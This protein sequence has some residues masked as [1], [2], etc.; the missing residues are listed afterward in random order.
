[1]VELITTQG[2][3]SGSTVIV[4]LLVVMLCA[5]GGVAFWLWRERHAAPASAPSKFKLPPRA[6][7]HASPQHGPTPAPHASP[8]HGPTPAPHAS[9]QHGPTPAPQS[10]HGPTPQMTVEGRFNHRGVYVSVLPVPDD[11]SAF[12]NA[13][14]QIDQISGPKVNNDYDRVIAVSLLNSSLPFNLYNIGQTTPASKVVQMNLGVIFD[15]DCFQKYVQCMSVTDSGSAQ[16]T[17]KYKVNHDCTCQG[18]ESLN[19]EKQSPAQQAGCATKCG[20]GSTACDAI[21]WCPGDMTATQ[22]A[23]E[24]AGD[25]GIDQCLFRPKGNMDTYVDAAIQW[26]Q[27]YTSPRPHEWKWRETELDAVLPSGPKAQDAVNQCIIGFLYYCT[28]EQQRQTIKTN[29]IKAVRAF[30]QTAGRQAELFEIGS[31]MRQDTFNGTQD[32][33]WDQNNYVSS[34]KAF[35]T[36]IPLNTP[37]QDFS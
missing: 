1:M 28:D 32:A 29:M 4:L 16:R 24:Y 14:Y 26:R 17:C 9:P 31:G 36:K 35:A 21:R 20:D 12:T 2:S 11:P 18:H 5:G 6:A 25:V 23:Q 34:W 22:F 27:A 19:C 3:S 8:Q 13:I 15:I 10:S 7:P 30:Q 37:A 33:T